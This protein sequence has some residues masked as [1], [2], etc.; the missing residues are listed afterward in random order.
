MMKL[1]FPGPTR[2]A[3]SMLC[4]LLYA[5]S[6]NLER[7]PQIHAAPAKFFEAD[8]R[9]VLTFV[10]YSD[11]GYEDEGGMLRQAGR[12]L[13]QYDPASTIVN[14]GATPGGIGA[15]YKLAKE[16]GFTTTGI[17]STQARVHEVHP[18]E[19]VDHVFYI[20]DES[21]GGRLEGTRKLSPTSAAVVRYSDVLVGIGGGA[22]ARDEL[23]TARASGKTVRFI[24]ADMN[25]AN[26]IKKAARKGNPV[27]DNFA[28]EASRAF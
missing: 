5:C 18:S 21:W 10:G 14:I 1:Q 22:V 16:R 13:S 3:V 20:P 7:G 9:T 2:V 25:H 23:L 24:P 15:V 26:A 19:F 17:V 8:T 27:P 4:C 12:V 6:S 11:S 28:G